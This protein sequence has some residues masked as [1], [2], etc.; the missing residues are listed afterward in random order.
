MKRLSLLDKHFPM[1]GHWKGLDLGHIVQVWLA[2]IL[3]E[4]DHRLN[5]VESWAGGL[6]I[7]LEKC[8]ARPVRSLDFT[9][10]RPNTKAFCNTLLVRVGMSKRPLAR[11][12][13]LAVN[14]LEYYTPA[15][16][17]SWGCLH[18]FCKFEVFVRHKFSIAARAVW[19]CPPI[20]CS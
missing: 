9:D 12:P 16:L 4:G 10:D 3:S 14:S 17:M 19:P 7:T 2:H 13:W 11:S 5:H 6:L 20:R 15:R 8:L 1:H 18:K